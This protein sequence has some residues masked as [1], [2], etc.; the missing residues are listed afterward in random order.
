VQQWHGAEN[1]GFRDTENPEGRDVG[2]ETTEGLRM[3]NK[4]KGDRH[5]KA[6]DFTA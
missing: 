4:N 3:Q 2:D 1:T 6:A 5:K